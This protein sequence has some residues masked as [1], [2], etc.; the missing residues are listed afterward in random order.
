MTEVLALPVF[1]EPPDGLLGRCLQEG[2]RGRRPAEGEM[3][4]EEAVPYPRLELEGSA[5]E[6]GRAYGEALGDM[7]PR[8]IEKEFYGRWGEGGREFG[9]KFLHSMEEWTPKAA[10]FLRGLSDSSGIPLDEL[11]MVQAHEELVHGVHCSMV[12]AGKDE[13]SDGKVYLGQNWDWRTSMNEFKLLLRQRTE[14]GLM[15]LTYAFCGLWSCAGM[16]SAGVALCWT[17]AYHPRTDGKAGEGVPTYAM[18]AEL[19]EKESLEE[20]VELISSCPNAGWFIFSLASPEGIVKVEA[21]PE[22]KAISHPRSFVA[23]SGGSF[24]SD[25]L[26]SKLGWEDL[27]PFQPAAARLSQLLVAYS[28]RLSSG[29]LLRFLSSHLPEDVKGAICEHGMKHATL[30]SMMFC[31][32]D[33]RCWFVPGPPCRNRA[34]E[35]ELDGSLTCSGG[36]RG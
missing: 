12:G 29:L 8:F 30:D 33:G 14:E 25:E 31:P 4:I 7:L 17:S 24:Q 15:V 11:A 21:S 5:Y 27:P 26:L 36:C 20:A 2:R 9:S 1:T 13:T 23:T 28:G 6:R 10:E 35:V 18:I 19:L 22:F 16:N 32:Q 34:F 3:R